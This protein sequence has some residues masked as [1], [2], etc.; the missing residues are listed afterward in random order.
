M[1]L[2]TGDKAQQYRS[3]ASAQHSERAPTRP[4]ANS[5]EQAREFEM[6]TVA[7]VASPPMAPGTG[8]FNIDPPPWRPRIINAD[9]RKS[10][11]TKLLLNLD[12]MPPAPLEPPRRARAVTLG[13]IAVGLLA[14]IVVA[15]V[16]LAGPKERLATQ[17]ET[18]TPPARYQRS[19][20]KLAQEAR[21]IVV[22]RTG[23]M[24][25]PLAIGVSLKAA[26]GGEIVIIE[27][28]ASG[29]KL[30]LGTSLGD[31]RWRI[32]TADLDKTFVAAPP[33]FVGVMNSTISLH[34]ADG[35]LLEKMPVR[36][37][38]VPSPQTQRDP[39]PTGPSFE[40]T[41]QSGDLQE[42]ASLIIRAEELLHNGE[43]AAA[44]LLLTRAALNGDARA[45][46][47]LGMTYDQAFLAQWGIVGPYANPNLARE[48]YDRATKFGPA[49]ASHGAS[50]SPKIAK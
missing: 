29:A 39:A 5:L 13:V 19:N 24:N 46:I 40:L 48:W 4:P 7:A 31:A 9:A 34:S 16:K 33:D 32:A 2:L 28:L 18:P 42:T 41:S 22:N 43:V 3:S 17:A 10:G 44:R 45:A 6:P 27:G 50:A 38:W 20:S 21:L 49:E 23:I 37:E 11:P 12:A 14:G 36:L 47:K 26:A 35:V 30:S 15:A 1:G 8:G 25:E